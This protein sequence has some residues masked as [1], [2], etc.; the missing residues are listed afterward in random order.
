MSGVARILPVLLAVALGL[1][2][3]AGMDLA[4][5]AQSVPSFE[6]WWGW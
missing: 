5:A 6:G 4:P 3:V 1:W 2:I